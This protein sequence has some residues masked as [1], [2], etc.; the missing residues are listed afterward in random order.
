MLIRCN[1]YFIHQAQCHSDVYSYI[2]G[3]SRTEHI[4]IQIPYTTKFSL[5]KNFTKPS[6]LCI[7]EIFGG[8]HFRQCCKGHHILNVIINTGQTIRAIKI[9]PIKANGEIGK[10]FLLAKISTYTVCF[11][12][13]NISTENKHCLSIGDII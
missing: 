11:T 5:D 9:S 13:N 6:Y 3:N 2:N 7:A 4:R 8:I 1:E 10:N 12:C